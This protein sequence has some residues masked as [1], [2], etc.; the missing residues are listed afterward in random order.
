MGWGDSQSLPDFSSYLDFIPVEVTVRY[1]PGCVFCFDLPWSRQCGGVSHI[2]IVSS[3][4]PFC[5][6]PVQRFTA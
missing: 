2:Q 3:G 1:P 5:W 6:F 4:I